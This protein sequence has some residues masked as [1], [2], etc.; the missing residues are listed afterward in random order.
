MRRLIPTAARILIA[1][2]VAGVV[3]LPTTPSAMAAT[4][5]FDC[6]KVGGQIEKLICHDDTLAALDRET[7]RLYRLARGTPG[8]TARQSNELTATRRGWIKGRNVCWKADDR[9]T[10]VR[11]RTLARVYELRRD[12]P[13]ARSR[14]RDGV[15]LGPWSFSCTGLAETLR[16]T[17]ANVDPSLAYLAWGDH[18]LV[19]TLGLSGSGARYVAYTPNG[20]SVF[21]NKG[22]NA[23][24]RMPDGKE[25]D[26]TEAP[27]R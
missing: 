11:D 13:A 6:G 10:C 27:D 4:P 17:F 8:L 9:E 19:M 18:V 5:S 21:W 23:S 3:A 22:R 16:V 15:S 25:T 24:F 7:A 12:Y 26:C 2:A 14:D 1:L 20:E